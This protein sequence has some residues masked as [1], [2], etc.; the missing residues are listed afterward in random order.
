[1]LDFCFLAS[2]YDHKATRKQET[3]NVC[4]YILYFYSR[5]FSLFMVVCSFSSAWRFA[6]AFLCQSMSTIRSALFLPERK[7]VIVIYSDCIHIQMIIIGYCC[8]L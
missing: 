4:G 3:I 6:V 7:N 5:F 1:M 2:I 8:L